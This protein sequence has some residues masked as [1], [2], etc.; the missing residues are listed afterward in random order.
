MNKP[1]IIYALDFGK[2]IFGKN[3]FEPSIRLR[4]IVTK[5]IIIIVQS[6]TYNEFENRCAL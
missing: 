1:I 5:L 6:C 2:N 3:I 4:V